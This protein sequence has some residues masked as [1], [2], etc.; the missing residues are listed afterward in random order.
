MARALRMDYPDTWYHV[1]SRG[2]ERRDIFY[3]EEDYCKFLDI[4]GRMVERFGVEIHAYV[5]MR[6]H[7]SMSPNYFSIRKIPNIFLS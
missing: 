4:V 7:F 1:L 6:N 5:L 3:D 2:N